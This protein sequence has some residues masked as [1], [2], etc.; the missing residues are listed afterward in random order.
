MLRNEE[1]ENRHGTVYSM[2]QGADGKMEDM[3]YAGDWE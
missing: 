3:W 2:A 1:T